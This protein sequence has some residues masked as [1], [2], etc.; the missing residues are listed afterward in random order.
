MRQC[1]RDMKRGKRRFQK[2]GSGCENHHVADLGNDMSLEISDVP[3]ERVS[4]RLVVELNFVFHDFL[5][6]LHS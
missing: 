3:N 6:Q 5:P 1:L 4:F 2:F